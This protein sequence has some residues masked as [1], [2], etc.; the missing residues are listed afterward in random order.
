VADKALL[1]GINKYKSISHLRGCINDVHTVQSLLA[2]VF[3]FPAA[4]IRTLTDSQVTKERIQRSG[5]G[6]SRMLARAT[7]SYSISRAMARTSR[8]KMQTKTTELTN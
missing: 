4:N 8:T 7:V 1:T 2:D 5:T 6:S 3:D